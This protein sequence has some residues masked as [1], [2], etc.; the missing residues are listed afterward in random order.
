MRFKFSQGSVTVLQ[1][2]GNYKE[3]RVKLTN[4]QQIKMCSKN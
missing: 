4:T 1:K 3:A 2:I